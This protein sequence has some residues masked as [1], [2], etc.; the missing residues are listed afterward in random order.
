MTGALTSA[1]VAVADEA[2][3]VLSLLSNANQ[4]RTE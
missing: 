3:Q 1:S 2:P 4:P